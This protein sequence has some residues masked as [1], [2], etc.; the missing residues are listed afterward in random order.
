VSQTTWTTSEANSQPPEDGNRETHDVIP[1][2]I[3]PLS[4]TAYRV[5]EAQHL[6]VT[7]RWVH[8]DSDQALLEELLET[9]KPAPPNFEDAEGKHVDLSGHHYLLCTPFRY[10]PPLRGGTRF[11]GV[12]DPPVWYAAEDVATALAERS[13]HLLREYT[14]APGV[15]AP[16][17]NEWADFNIRVQTQRGIDLYDEAFEPHRT[18]LES[19]I[20]YQQPQSLARDCRAQHVQAIRFR[21]ARDPEQADH[22][23]ARGKNLAV[24]TPIAFASKDID[25][26]TSRTWSVI[27]DR[28]GVRIARKNTL[29]LEPAY[30]FNAA[31]FYVDGVV[32]DPV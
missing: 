5:I 8:D 7:R 21:S 10:R 12:M 15:T 16:S 30:R 20:D 18:G 4:A 26:T 9:T 2:P 3:A 27:A 11:G 19:K 6:R 24:L 31:V 32:P 28:Q 22:N 29:S 13:F 23:P 25:L 17:F 14:R 1:L